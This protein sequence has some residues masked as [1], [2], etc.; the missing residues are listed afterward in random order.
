MR[1]FVAVCALALMCSAASSEPGLNV[2]E[3]SLTDRFVARGTNRLSAGHTETRMFCRF[4]G[5]ALSSR[6]WRI[7]GRC[8]SGGVSGRVILLLDQAERGGEYDLSVRIPLARLFGYRAHYRYAGSVTG[9]R[10]VFSA[11]FTF[12]GKAYHSRFT[13]AFGPSGIERITESVTSASGGG[14]VRLVDLAI[15]PESAAP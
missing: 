9:N 8:A 15:R 1:L 10:A 12:G 4:S 11:P 7:A 13:I 14:R 3:R 6:R 2:F 5:K